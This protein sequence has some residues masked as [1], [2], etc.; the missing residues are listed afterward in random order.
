MYIIVVPLEFTPLPLLLTL[1]PELVKSIGTPFASES[2]LFQTKYGLADELNVFLPES[3]TLKNPELVVLFN[4][5]SAGL[6]P[7]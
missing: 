7:R 5:K 1:K 6:N 4:T 2:V 3:N